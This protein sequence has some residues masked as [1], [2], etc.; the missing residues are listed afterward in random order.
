MAANQVSSGPQPRRS[1]GRV[2]PTEANS[3]AREKSQH[4]QQRKNRKSVAS[5]SSDS[6]KTT[7][8]VSRA[9]RLARKRVRKGRQEGKLDDEVLNKYLGNL[10]H[11]IPSEKRDS[12]AYIECL[13]FAMYQKGD[14][15]KALRWI[16]RERIFSKKYVFLPI[17][18]WFLLDIYEGEGRSVSKKQIDKIP[19]LLPKV[20][21]QTGDKECG[22]YVLY[23]ITE[24]LKSFPEAFSIS[25]NNPNFMSENWFAAED[26]ESFRKTLP[27][28][29]QE[30]CLGNDLS[31]GGSDDVVFIERQYV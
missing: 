20:P 4:P 17:C 5:D 30:T 3:S 21:Q 11:K 6:E 7:A 22:Y 18:L 29:D 26:V 15:E 19:L 16:R 28:L 13:W 1:K 12:C 23:Y 10:W 31:D 24:F 25:D 14:R 2:H 27:S 9:H 8:N